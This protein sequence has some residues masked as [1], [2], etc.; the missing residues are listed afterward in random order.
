VTEGYLNMVHRADAAGSIRYLLSES[1]GH[2]E[3]LLVCD[4]E[5]ADKWRFADWL[6][7]QCDREP[8]E[9]QT[10]AERLAEADLS[11]PA[12]RRIHTSKR[13]DNGRLHEM[14]YEF[15]YP[16][17]RD[18]YRDAVET[19]RETVPAGGSNEADDG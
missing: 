6:A 4:D 5:P 18:G 16:T 19:Y 13:C 15:D 1:L 12:R 7:E 3:V 9:K 11:E 10:K 17:Y 8:A 14:G 2:D